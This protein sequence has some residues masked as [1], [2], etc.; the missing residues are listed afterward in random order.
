MKPDAS[1]VEPVPAA[2]PEPTPPGGDDD[3]DDDD[4]WGID[5]ELDSEYEPPFVKADFS[6]PQHPGFTHE[7][8]HDH[9]WFFHNLTAVRVNPLGLTNRFRTGYKMQLSHRPEAIFK[10]SYATIELDT[11]LTP[12]FGYAGARMEIQPAKIFNFWASYGVIGSFG[13]FS[14]TRS[15]PNSRA[16]YDD[17]LLDATEDQD[18]A[19]LGHRATVSGMFQFGLGGV[20]MRNN[21]KGHFQGMDLKE[22]DTTFYDAALDIL[23]PNSGW[24]VTNDADLLV[25]TEFNLIVGVRYTVTAP[26]YRA[27]HLAVTNVTQ[28]DENGPTHRVGPAFIYEFFDDGEG[29]AWNKPSIVLLAQWWAKHRYRTGTAPA[30]PYLVLAFVQHGDW[31]MSD[32]K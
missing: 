27:E 11:E 16:Q 2:K 10:E 8:A 19:T 9:R 22:G 29:A 4:D 13:T 31:M 32:K 23:M 14:H 15:F 12:A 30:L 24:V 6:R 25:L 1:L 3:D 28:K 18:Y 20:A 17:D 21:V 7:P 5:E 26:I